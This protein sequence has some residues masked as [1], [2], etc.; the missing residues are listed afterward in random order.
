[1]T[2]RMNSGTLTGL[3]LLSCSPFLFAQP[4]EDVKP[5]AVKDLPVNRWTKLRCKPEL[6]HWLSGMVYAPNRGQI[7]HWGGNRGPAN[8]A[9]GSTRN[10]VRAFDPATSDW[11]SDYPSDAKPSAGGSGTMLPSGHP[12]ASSPHVILN[13]VCWDSKRERAVYTMRGLMAAYD[14]KTKTWTDLK[15]KTVM[16]Y[17]VND[18]DQGSEAK[19]EHPG[20][21]PVYGIGTCYDPVNDEIVLFPHYYAKNISMREATG[22]ITGH[23]GTFRY[24]FKDN[25]WRVVSE[26]FGTDEMKAARKGLIG[27]M[28]KTSA[29][30]DAA[31]VLNRRPD[32][33]KAAEV[34]KRF[35]AA[36]AE[37]GKLPLP[38]DAKAGL[39]QVAGLLKTA[40]ASK[41]G[42]ASRPAR[43][44]LWAMN[45]VLDGALRV[46]PPPRCAAPM[47][48]DPKNKCIVMFGGQTNVA[49]TDLDDPRLA[50][51]WTALSDTWVYDVKTRQWR[52]LATKGRPPGQ[53]V[54]K[55]AYD[56]ES[57]LVL[58]VATTGA[59]YDQ[60]IPR[61]I[62][63]WTLD[64]AK[65]EWLKRD[66]QDWQDAL[67]A[68]NISASTFGYDP[69]RRLMLI[70]KREKDVDATYALKLDLAKLPGQPAPA[71]VPPPPIKP[72]EV[73]P[74]D[75]E[76]VAKIKKVPANTWV[77]AKPSPETPAR[78]WGVISYDAAHDWVV[79]FGGGH[80]TY[81]RNNVAIYPVG[82]NRWA[83]TVGDDNGFV[84]PNYWEGTC[85]G[86]RGGPATGH[87]RNT[88]QTFDGRLY[89]LIAAYGRGSNYTYFPDAECVYFYDINRGGLWRE[90][91]IAT[92][93]QP[94]E[95]VQRVKKNR[96]EVGG[97]TRTVQMV[98]PRGRILDLLGMPDRY[99]G[100][101]VKYYFR[102]YDINENK[103]TVKEVPA[104]FPMSSGEC[105]NYCYIPD[106][107]QILW[108]E[109]NHN[110]KDKNAPG[111]KR[112]WV[113]DLKENKFTD[114]KP[115]HDL[116]GRPLVV[117]YCP[118]QKVALAVFSQ[119]CEQWVY[120]FEKNDWAP[121]EQKADGFQVRV[122]PPYG[123]MVWTGKHG[124]FVNFHAYT[125][126]TLM[127]PDFSR[128]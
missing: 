47:V 11:V 17:L 93:E 70:T 118:A 54:P 119:E 123:Q 98:D 102:C 105:R 95:Y 103:L 101:P 73:P 16:P 27:V 9:Q 56:P 127:R 72:Q 20:G 121:L 25:T 114:M 117:E 84:P 3:I 46:E 89:H 15:A 77:R 60:K 14:P 43:D 41:P 10:D 110:P 64:V 87:Q 79:F 94:E 38:A 85:I 71:W 120:S 96:A 39:A 69:V 109:Y 122:S 66:E 75:P 4:A 67:L 8:N 32:A 59:I 21:P 63:L 83:T 57:G 126:V 2:R 1:M 112:T 5:V 58:L 128:V 6:G 80:S 49:R 108:C 26:T 111:F 18:Y 125:G 106:R 68:S 97:V 44:A 53:H 55:L 51:A 62:S 13:G 7:L 124:V 113:Y 45:E 107:D 76:W 48:Y 116:P 78:D 91:R 99:A 42:D 61:K 52:E 31:W 34:A 30:M 40:A 86:H 36:A 100:Q 104:P 82:A 50:L 29:T 37:I 12:A 74:E 115:K 28:A 92:I 33:G 81:Q 19:L 65:A 90:Q 24:S 88:Y 35:D 23:H 22:Q